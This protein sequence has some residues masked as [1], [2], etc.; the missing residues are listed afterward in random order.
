ML[1]LPTRAAR[2]AVVDAPFSSRL[3]VTGVSLMLQ[4]CDARQPGVTLRAAMPQR[5]SGDSAP[6]RPTQTPPSRVHICA[7]AGSA[8]YTM[9][10]LKEVNLHI[11]TVT[12]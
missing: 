10:A 1:T 7:V 5:S 4:S 11:S 3:E 2:F 6:N 9:V 8:T 12:L